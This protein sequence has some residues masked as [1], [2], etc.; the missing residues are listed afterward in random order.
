MNVK[1]LI[2]TIALLGL[3]GAQADLTDNMVVYY[4]FEETGSAGLG[5]KAPGAAL[6]DA[7]TTAA[8]RTG[9][10]ATGSGFAGNAAY[11]AGD[12][13]GVSDRGTLLA[14]KAINFADIDNDHIVAPLGTAELGISFSISTWTYLA[15]GPGNTSSR[16]QAFESSNNYDVSWGNPSDNTGVMRP[17]VGQIHVVPDTSITHEQWQHV[18]HVFSPEGANTRLRVY[19]DGVETATGTSLTANMDFAALHFGDARTSAYG[20]RGWD[21]MLDEVAIWDRALDAAEVTELRNLG[22]AGQAVPEPATL[23][24]VIAFGGGMVFVRRKL[25]M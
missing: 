17:Y 15:P 4:D 19:A 9:T 3:G 8:W 5:N 16:F 11:D 13:S 2:L 18:V 7:T 6:Y 12:G 25:M 23:G 14:G 10:D 21:G 24:L 22:L 1:H 20:D